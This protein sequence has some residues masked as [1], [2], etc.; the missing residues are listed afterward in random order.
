LVSLT[1]RVWKSAFMT[2]DSSMEDLVM[3]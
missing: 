1:P 3:A 2:E